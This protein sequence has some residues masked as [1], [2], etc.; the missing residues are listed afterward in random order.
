MNSLPSPA[1]DQAAVLARWDGPLLVLGGPGTG[2]TTLLAHAAVARSLGTGPPPLVLAASRTAASSLRN[3]IAAGLGD[4]SW[5]PAVTTVHALCRTIWQRFA[6]RPDLRLL[7]APEQ[8]YR[9]RELLAASG[10]THWPA[11]LRPALGTRGFATQV[12]AAIAR[13][14]Q[15]GLEPEDLTAFGADAGRPEWQALGGFFLEYL[16]VLDAEGVLDYAE[17]VHRVRLLLTELDIATILGSEI[18][19]VLID[20]YTELDPAQIALLATLAGAA[21]VLAVADPDSVSST[22]RGAHPRAVPDFDRFFGRPDA[23]GRVVSLTMGHRYGPVIAGAL[24]GVRARL[25]RPAGAGQPEP[26]AAATDAGDGEV[27]VITCSGEADQAEAIAAEIRR[28]RLFDGVRYGDMAVLVRSGRRQLGPIVRSL[29]AAGIPV[30]VAGDEIPLARAPSVRPLLLALAVTAAGRVAPDE[31]VRLLTSPLAGFDALGLRRL[32]RQW[33]GGGAT[34]PAG[35]PEQLAAAVNDAAWLD[36]AEV[37]PVTQ[38][39]RRLLEVLSAAGRRVRAGDPVDLVAWTL[40]QGTDWPRQLARESLAGGVLGSRADADLDA[41]CALFDSAAEA[42]RRG[43]VAGIRAFLAELAGQQIPAD[44]ERESRLRGRGVQVLTAH[45][46][47]GREWDLVVV[48]GVQEGV[49]PVGRRVSTVLDPAALTTDGLTGRTDHRDLLAAERRLF[50]LACSRARRRLVVTAA[51]GTEGEADSPSRFLA[52]LG[53]PS[54][55]PDRA[56][57]PLTPTA[58][59]A[60][61]RRY[62]TDPATPVELRKAAA[63]ELARLADAADDTGRV[64]VPAADPANWWGVRELS[65][66]PQPLAS[67]GSVRLSP[68]QVTGILTC[69]RHYFLAREARGE[70]EPGLA[71]ALGSLIHLLVQQAVNEGWGLA[72]LRS[73]LDRVWGRLRFEAAWLSATERVEVELGLARFLAWREAGASELVGVEVPFT[74]EVAVDDLTVVLD[75]KVDWLERAAGGLRVVDFKTSRSAPTRAAIAGMEQLGIYQLAVATGGFAG[76]AAEAGTAGAAAVYLRLPGR[77]EDLPKEF[78]QDSLATTPYLGTGPEEQR[79]PTWVHQ[80]IALAA[81]VVADGSYPATPGTHCRT[82]PFANSCPA[83]GRGGQVLR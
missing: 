53:V 1:A 34:A 61:L 41:L 80:R 55:A 21:P 37:T 2:K 15:L 57:P 69:P 67:G 32:A 46:A 28:A 39:L 71:A 66:R 23:P 8:E 31:A 4:G 13:A 74:L 33:R 10:A 22:F 72:E 50:H 20:D 59:A 81:G 78:G 9:V 30:E 27:Q 48:A 3:A 35:L 44:N 19:A 12:R 52:E 7:A 76:L 83:S 6:G 70:G 75:G 5:Q 43:G 24:G 54:A 82:C 16:D 45:R 36:T 42:D 29:A 60:E 73:R 25:P 79:Y 49:W 65:S 51:A 63:V 38:R 11:E 17:L 18:G 77:P 47:R 40:W 62:G 58:L 64:L 68:S 56:R 26:V 14:R